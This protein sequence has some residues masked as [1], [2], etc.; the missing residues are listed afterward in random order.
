MSS[1]MPALSR[2]NAAA[3]GHHRQ[4]FLDQVPG[5]AALDAFAE[6]FNVAG[7]H[8][9]RAGDG[10]H[11]G[12]FAGAV[13][14][15]QRDQLAFVDFKIDALDGLNAAVGDFEAGHFEECVRHCSFILQWPV[16]R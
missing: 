2:E 3:F 13:G 9:Q 1:A 10:F 14:A 4:A 5:A 11:R 16:P 8:R 7:H 12:G 6:V 15:D